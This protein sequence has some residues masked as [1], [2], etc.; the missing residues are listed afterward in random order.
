[1]SEAVSTVLQSMGTCGFDYYKLLNYVHNKNDRKHKVVCLHLTEMTQS[2]ISRKQTLE[3]PSLIPCPNLIPVL[4]LS[5]LWTF[6][7]WFC[8]SYWIFKLL[9]LIV[10]YFLSFYF[11]VFKLWAL[12][13][14]E[15]EW[16]EFY[17]LTF[18]IKIFKVTS[19]LLRGKLSVSWGL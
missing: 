12:K 13:L 6:W 11:W 17:K 10:F 18:E 1:M 5:F 3:V 9:F 4:I 15:T 16:T 7:F 14:V 8:F 2:H 19:F